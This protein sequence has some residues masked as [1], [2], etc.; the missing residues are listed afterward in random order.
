M[1]TNRWSLAIDFGTSYSVAAVALEGEPPRVL[2]IDGEN[3]VPSVVLVDEDRIIVGRV[4]EEM[5]G[6]Q[7]GAV[8]RA[9]KSRLGDQAPVV[10][11]G[12]TFPV[13]T[14][15]AA[16][17]QKV[18]FEAITQVGCPPTNARLTHPA[19]WTRTKQGRLIEAAAI[20]GLPPVALVPEPVAAAMSYWH[21]GEL[22]VGGYVAV[23]DL[24]GGTFDSAV[25]MAMADGFKIVGR[26]DGD[27][28]LGGELF[29]EL[30]VNLIGEQLP[31]DSWESIQLG[32]DSSSRQVAAVLRQ[33]ARRAKETLSSYHYAE[34]LI[35]LSTG[36]VRIRVNRE[37]FEAAIA[38]YIGDSIQLLHRCL[39]ESRVNPGQLTAL[40]LVGGS[41]RIPAVEAALRRAFPGLAIHR[42]GDPKHA[43]A[44]GA[45]IASDSALTPTPT[46]YGSS[47]DALISTRR[48]PSRD[49]QPPPVPRQPS[50]PP[51]PPQ[52]LASG[53]PLPTTVVASNPVFH[54]PPQD[55]AGV[56]AAPAT[57]PSPDATRE[58]PWFRRK[59]PLVAV[60]AALLLAT[61]GGVFFLTRAD[62]PPPT[63]A[64]PLAE[65]PDEFVSIGDIGP[66]LED[67]AKYYELPDGN[68]LRDLRR[69]TSTGSI[70]LDVPR[71]WDDI[72]LGSP[73]IIS[74]DPPETTGDIFLASTNDSRLYAYEAGGIF[75]AAVPAAVELPD[76][77]SQLYIDNGCVS[78]PEIDVDEPLPGVVHIWAGCTDERVFVTA[79]MEGD[80]ARVSIFA[81]ATSVPE[82]AA[83]GIALETLEIDSE[84]ISDQP[85]TEDG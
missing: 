66:Y 69:E 46:S 31:V 3:R 11:G 76:E 8:L 1:G 49:N 73:L 81:L 12:R 68:E 64:D 80:D 65:I 51:P 13:T 78:S 4:A 35:P 59:L 48:P 26:P 55:P 50:P 56:P 6:S 83:I 61:V 2:T 67:I 36:L 34:V 52:S 41:S 29:D 25:L 28:G 20:A 47:Q 5:T 22:P 19:T 72:D 45:L 33:E 62:E 23:Y 18:Y 82:A 54:R 84:S 77:N 32:G 44:L 71:D 60:G 39:E 27:A 40:Q 15:V 24:G 9:P 14:L 75:I 7:A 38:T 63:A 37:T 16:I 10:L 85:G 70:S 42:R 17:L 74:D 43:V 53:R 21:Q 30:I 58:V 79:N 57:A